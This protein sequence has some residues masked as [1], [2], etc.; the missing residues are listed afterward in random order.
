[1]ELHILIPAA[2]LRGQVQQLLQAL[3]AVDPADREAAQG[4]RR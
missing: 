4:Q 3:Q 1:M 2:L